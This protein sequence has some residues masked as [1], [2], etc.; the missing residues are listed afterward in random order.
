VSSNPTQA[1][2]HYRNDY[3]IK[4]DSDATGWWFSLGTPVS[5]TNKTDHQDITEILLKM[6]LSTINPNPLTIQ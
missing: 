2:Q 5:T 6:V 3:V 4:F 1:I